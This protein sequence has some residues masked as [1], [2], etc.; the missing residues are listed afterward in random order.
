[1][2]LSVTLNPCI[3]HLMVVD[4]LKVHDRNKVLRVETDAGGKGVNLS[5]MVAE[6]GGQTVA[7]GFLGGQT[8][9][10]VRRVLESEGVPVDFVEIRGET[11]TNVSVES[12]DGPPTVFGPSGPQVSPEDWEALLTKVTE[13]L[14]EGCWMCLGGSLPP[15]VP[16]GAYETLIRHAHEHGARVLLDA[17]GEVLKSGL[18]A[19][20]DMVKPNRD[21]AERLLGVEI[22]SLQDAIES[23]QKIH[24]LVAGHGQGD[25]ISVVSLGSKGAVLARGKKLLYGRG[26]LIEA[27]STI[28]SGD[29]FNGAFLSSLS[30]GKSLS[31]ALRDGISAGMA[32]AVSDGAHIGSQQ[33]FERFKPLVRIVDREEIESLDGI[34]DEFGK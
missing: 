24:G 4:G 27:K 13:Y 33:D 17:D 10:H 30:R 25:G 5:R 14:C 29:S 2:I 28:G 19:A 7:T 26:P 20:P 3:D 31:D 9:D 11:R 8:G 23:V 6:L 18:K 1:M 15:G 32:T 12:G 21:E 34:G 22:R 16:T